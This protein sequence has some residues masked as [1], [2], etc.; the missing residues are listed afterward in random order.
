MGIVYRQVADKKLDNKHPIGKVTD[1]SILTKSLTHNCIPDNFENM[2]VENYQ[3]LL[4]KRRRLM[5]AKIEKYY[6]SL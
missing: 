3:E 4:E 1:A 6:K 2:T 5:V